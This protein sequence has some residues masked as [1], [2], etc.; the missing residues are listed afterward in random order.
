M[1][2]KTAENTANFL[3]NCGI[4]FKFCN[5]WVINALA[6]GLIALCIPQRSL[7]LDS[8]LPKKFVFICFNKR[9]LKMMKNACSFI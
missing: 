8:H 7:K 1:S 5:F 6:K 4:F 3:K 9:P 2:L